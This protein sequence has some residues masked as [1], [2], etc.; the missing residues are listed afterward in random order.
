[1]TIRRDF[2]QFYSL[3]DIDELVTNS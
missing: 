2:Y 3:Y 1:M